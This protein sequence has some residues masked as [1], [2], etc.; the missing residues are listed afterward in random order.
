IFFI[1]GRFKSADRQLKIFFYF[2]LSS[3]KKCMLFDKYKKTRLE[4]GNSVE[5]QHSRK[6]QKTQSSKGIYPGVYR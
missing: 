2:F 3:E 5:K 6:P 4:Y 1:K